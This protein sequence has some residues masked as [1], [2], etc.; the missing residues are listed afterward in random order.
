MFKKMLGKVG[1]MVAMLVGIGLLAAACNP[2]VMPSEVQTA[3]EEDAATEHGSHLPPETF[4]I[5]VEPIGHWHVGH[6]KTLLFTV[7]QMDDDKSISGLNLVVQI[8]RSGSSRVSE[9]SVENEQVVDEGEGVYSLE[10]TAS[11]MD[12]YG[13][14]ARFMH[15]GVEFVSRPLA[16]EVVRDGE[17]GIRVDAQD[18][19]YV[20]QIRYNWEPGHI[21]ANDTDAVKLHF[22]IMRGVP[23]GTEIDWERPWQNAF[24][25]INDAQDPVAFVESEDGV[26][27]EE[28][29][30]L[31]RG[32]GI[33]QAER[34]FSEAEVG[35]GMAYNV[36]FVFTDP[37][38]GAEV[39]HTEPYPLHAVPGH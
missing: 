7:A 16:F 27:I 33:Y 12:S 20:Y 39:T 3:T 10:Y 11:D 28:L 29:P 38:T 2:V 13:L 21:H 24:D 35:E 22:E 1:P 9:R 30:V 26:V 37:Y 34:V 31:Y 8:V 6:A 32:K 17:E 25:H 14:V 4:Y 23:E 36:H 18:T 15:E 19:S 5:N